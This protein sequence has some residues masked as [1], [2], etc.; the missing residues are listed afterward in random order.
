MNCDT[1]SQLWDKKKCE[2]NSHL[3]DKKK[4]Q[5]SDITVTHNYQ[6][7]SPLSEINSQLWDKKP[8]LSNITISHN[9]HKKVTADW[10]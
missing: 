5:L 7:K 4:P 2:N 10:Y 1:N 6:K 3:W 9:Y 8:Q